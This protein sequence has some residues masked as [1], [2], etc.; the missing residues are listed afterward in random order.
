MGCLVE[1]HGKERAVHD[2]REGEIGVV[3]HWCE[4]PTRHQIRLRQIPKN[5][6][7]FRMR[8]SPGQFFLNMLDAFLFMFLSMA[9]TIAW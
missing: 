5:L 7:S 6:H 9:F 3:L 2:L 4:P 8:L 1:L